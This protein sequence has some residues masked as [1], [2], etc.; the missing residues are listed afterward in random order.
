MDRIRILMVLDNTGRGG[1]QSF[2]MNVCRHINWDRFQ[3]DIAITRNKRG[4]YDEEMAHLGCQIH[5]LVHFELLNYRQYVS[6]WN[7][8]LDENHYDIVHGNVSGPAAIYLRIAHQHGCVTILHS[9]SSGYRGNWIERLVKRVMAP[10]AKHHADLWFACAHQAA[11]RLFGK[12]Y[13]V[14]SRY[15]LIPNA[16]DVS[17]YKFDESIRDLV[18]SRHNI[19]A[20]TFVCGHVGSFSRP[21]NHEFLLRVFAQ[22]HKNKP[23]SKLLLVGDG[24]L[25]EEIVTLIRKMDLQEAVIMTGNV[26]NV[27][28]YLMAMDVMIFP[29]LFEGFGL[30]VLE[31]QASGLP[32]IISNTI[33][34]DVVL[35]DLV[36]SQSLNDSPQKWADEAL[37]MASMPR[38]REDYNQIIADT[39]YNINTSISNIERLYDS[40]I[41]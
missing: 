16:I 9:H 29:S 37:R 21:K 24:Y 27:E 20:S 22:L 33:P 39:P 23:D 14:D 7:S 19:S 26:G 2:V 18:R 34:E 36:Q 40:L 41:H 12:D 10:Y 17:C 3:I 28:E 4:G 38:N 1:S 35:S 25:R 5:N 30:A 15:Q 13:V 11:I 32:T 31:S 6:C 8:F